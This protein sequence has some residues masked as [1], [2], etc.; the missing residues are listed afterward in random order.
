MRIKF[1][2]LYRDT[3]NETKSLF[4]DL[5]SVASFD[6]SKIEEKEWNNLKI[7]YFKIKDNI[8]MLS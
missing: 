7:E 8:L 2:R 6:L 4:E 3:L 5:L 1:S